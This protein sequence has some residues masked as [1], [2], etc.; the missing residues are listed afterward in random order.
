[1]LN[2]IED[3]CVG[4][5]PKKKILNNQQKTVMLYFVWF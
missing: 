3:L 2:K 5:Y 4:V 1:M